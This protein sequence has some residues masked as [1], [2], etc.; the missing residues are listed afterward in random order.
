MSTKITYGA[1]ISETIHSGDII[2]L[3][4]AGHKMG[5]NIIVECMD[6]P[7]QDDGSYDEGYAEGYKIGKIDGIAEGYDQGVGD[8]YDNGKADGL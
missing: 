7:A 1:E 2:E 8:G 4:C 6:E 5:A 3:E